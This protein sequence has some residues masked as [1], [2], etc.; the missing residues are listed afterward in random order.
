[1]RRS[2]GVSAIVRWLVW[3]ALF[4]ALAL[5]GPVS[6]AAQEVATISLEPAQIRIGVGEEV[7][8]QVVVRGATNLYALEMQ[9]EFDARLLEVLDDD[10]AQEGVQATFVGGFLEPD[11]V[12]NNEADNERGFV[13]LAFTQE[14]P[15]EGASGEGVLATFRVRG[16]AEGEVPVKVSSVILFDAELARAPARTRMATVYVG[17]V[18]APP[19]ASATPTTELAEPTP[20]ATLEPTRTE[21]PTEPATA[22]PPPEPTATLDVGTE[23]AASQ[24]DTVT[25]EGQPSESGT[26]SQSPLSPPTRE[27]GV[28]AMSDSPIGTPTLMPARATP[29]TATPE[30]ETI[31]GSADGATATHTPVKQALAAEGTPAST[32]APARVD[33]GASPAE[34]GFFGSMWFIVAVVG[35]L[36]AGFGLLIVLPR[37]RRGR[38]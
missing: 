18:P 7:T 30:P 29:L 3:V 24:E 36:I 28:V 26:W 33:A 9:A 19:E 27:A 22:T 8:L 13:A 11:I 16:K 17:D 32:G 25:P 23:S 1:M 38:A 10:P 20:T 37:G 14:A 35:V 2:G 12:L 15:R 21:V 31:R 6:A 34:S 4:W 5:M